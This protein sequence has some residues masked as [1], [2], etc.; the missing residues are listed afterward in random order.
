MGQF[1]T[2][3]FLGTRARFQ[4]FSDSEVFRGWIDAFTIKLLCV[5]LSTANLNPGERF[6]FHV[7][8][9][10][11]NARFI[12]DLLAKSETDLK[13]PPSLSSL[14][15]TETPEHAGAYQYHFRVASQF[16][17]L[18]RSEEARI[19]MDGGIIEVNSEECGEDRVFLSDISEH[20]AGILGTSAYS[21][22]AI[23]S[24]KVSAARRTLELKG[25]VRYCIRS[26]IVPDMYKTGLKLDGLDRLEAAEWRNLMRAA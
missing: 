24:L 4:R 15:P 19:A 7:A 16:E 20:G 2:H 12:G 13:L 9:G 8:N 3:G 1:S 17:Y 25:E 6:V 18:P 11:C 23:L 5:R 14:L 22:G 21:R 10:T 26:K